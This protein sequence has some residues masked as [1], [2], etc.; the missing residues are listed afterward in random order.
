MDTI[1]TTLNELAPGLVPVVVTWLVAKVRAWQPGLPKG[2]ALALGW[3]LSALGGW[4]GD[5]LGFFELTPAAIAALA[6]LQTTTYEAAK[7]LGWTG[8]P[9]PPGG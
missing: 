5:A 3:G 9:T 6:G 2:V 1:V 7:R 4:A 8:Q